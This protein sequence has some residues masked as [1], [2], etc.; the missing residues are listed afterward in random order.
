MPNHTHLRT[1]D[2]TL[3]REINLS[4]IMRR[5]L[6]HASLSRASLAEV[7]GLNKSTVSSLVQELIDMSFV[8]ETG[9]SSTG[10]GRCLL[11]TSPSPRDS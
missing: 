11:Y 7:T 5:L 1:G 3:V 10:V 8:H 2:Q 6:E 4:V 9:L